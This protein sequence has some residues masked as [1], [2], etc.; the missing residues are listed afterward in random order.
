ME[1]EVPY[2]FEPRHYQRPIFEAFDQGVKRLLLVQHRR[3]GK[4]KCCFNLMVRAAFERVGTYFYFL[5]TFAQGRR[6]IWH[7]MD[8][9]G[10]K[11][12]SHIP[13]GTIEKTN[14]TDMRIHLRTGSIIQIVG[15][16]KIDHIVGTNPVGAVF[17]EYSV[18]DP[19]GWD[20]V[21]PILR[22]NGGWALLNGTP[23]GRANHLFKQY[24][25]ACKSDEWFVQRLGIDETGVMSE[26]DVRAEIE[27]GMSEELAKQEFYVSFDGGLEGAYY[28]SLLNDMQEQG[29]TSGVAYDPIL[30]VHTSWDIGMA[31]STAIV[32]F[33]VSPG[34]QVRMIDF[35]EAS[36]EGLQYYL[37]I[38]NEKSQENGYQYGDHIAPH[39][40][41][42]REY[43]S[44]KS[45]LEM[46]RSMGV[47]F[48]PC[49]KL[50]LH[51]G[52][53]AV[54]MMLPIAWIDGV[55]CERL[56]QALLEYTK[57][58]DRQNN[59]WRDPPARNWATHAADAV[60]YMAVG[61]PN[62]VLPESGR[63][64]DRYK[65]RAP[66]SWMAA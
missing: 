27:G 52:I 48:K 46:A 62:A 32:F 41:V 9:E 60:R 29:R 65:Y 64:A 59:R 49:R 6:V 16:D 3:A 23:R 4:D 8:K 58:W 20:F 47:N 19:R 17:S 66:T 63:Y 36:G 45:R 5:P 57:T 21:R 24:Q 13:P 35:H 42:V 11:F 2:K 1:V 30:P 51:D 44:G 18:Q 61:R 10:F 55:K 7:G 39:D 31:D 34:G 38:L 43:G 40:I 54:R 50:S 25:L 33:Q 22:E 28:S 26:E 37:Q 12:M 14:E 53:N 56:V 15:S